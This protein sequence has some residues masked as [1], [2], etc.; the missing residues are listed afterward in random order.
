ML[1]GGFG[2]HL[3]CVAL[4]I[5]L[6]NKYNIKIHMVHNGNGINNF[7][8][9]TRNTIFKI[10]NVS[11]IANYSNNTLNNNTYINTSQDYYNALYNYNSSSNYII[12]CIGIEEINIYIENITTIKNHLIINHNFN[13]DYENTITI[14]LRLGCYGEV[15]FP[16]PFSDEESTRL[17]FDYFIQGIKQILNKNENINT[18]LICCDNFEDDFVKKFEYLNN[19]GINVILNK[20]NTYDQFCDILNSKYFITSLSS[21]SLFAV[22]FSNNNCYVPYFKH[23]STIKKHISANEA[24]YV[25]ASNTLYS[26]KNINKIVI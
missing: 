17:P 18:L 4:G 14:S 19:Q 25:N 26:M 9:D 10:V 1:Q 22:I 24:W 21:F 7:S 12:N 8:K 15:C 11:I 23:N 20:K 16:S 13:Y 2:N 3:S 5:I 6:A